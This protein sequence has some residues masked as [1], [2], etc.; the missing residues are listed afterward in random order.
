M[1]TVAGG[2]LLPIVL[3]APFAEQAY[4]HALIAPILALTWVMLATLGRGHRLVRRRL[5][6]IP[7]GWFCGLVLAG[8]WAHREV[9]WWPLFGASRPH[10]ALFPPIALLLI[11]EAIGILAAVWCYSRFGLSDRARREQFLRY[12]RV[13]VVSS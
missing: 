12:G 10:V 11:E 2:A 7:I 4:A 13:S 8:S 9:F 3:D 1:R 5:L 6:G